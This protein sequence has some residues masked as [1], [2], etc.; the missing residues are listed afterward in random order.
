MD[1]RFFG[2]NEA[3]QSDEVIW[4]HSV[5]LEAVGEAVFTVLES[6]RKGNPVTLKASCKACK[7]V[8]GTKFTHS[9]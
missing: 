1:G 9:D 5:M 4:L 3:V 6:C 8:L 7:L 2:R